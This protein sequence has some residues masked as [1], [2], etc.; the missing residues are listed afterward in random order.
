L[1]WIDELDTTSAVVAEAENQAFTTYGR[2]LRQKHYRMHVDQ[3]S[4]VNRPLKAK[5]RK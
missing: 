5:D 2:I 1:H 3:I 4:S